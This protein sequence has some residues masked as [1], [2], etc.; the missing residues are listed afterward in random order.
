MNS[1]QN[2]YTPPELEADIPQTREVRTYHVGWDRVLLVLSIIVCAVGSPLAY[3]EIESIVGSGI[4]MFLVSLLLLIRE[5]YC[6]IRLARPAWW[7]TFFL[8]LFGLAFVCGIC[9]MIA[10][11]QWSPGAAKANYV[12]EMVACFSFLMV[13]GSLVAIFIPPSVYLHTGPAVK[14]SE[15]VPTGQR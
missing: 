9:A 13:G 15:T 14:S 2:P 6:R 11:L 10:L 1:I 7:L 3:Y 8:S 5:V 4:A 12:A